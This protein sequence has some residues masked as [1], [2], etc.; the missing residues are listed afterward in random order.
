GIAV[1]ED[2]RDGGARLRRRELDDALARELRFGVAEEAR[3]RSVRLDDAALLVERDPLEREVEELQHPRCS[4]APASGASSFISSAMLYFF[5]MRRKFE[6]S[7]PAAREA[8]L[9]LPAVRERSDWR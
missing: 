7:R 5:K 6:R 8:W 4:Y 1:G 9:M 3:E 2:A